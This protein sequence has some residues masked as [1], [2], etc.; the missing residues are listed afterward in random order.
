MQYAVKITQLFFFFLHIH[1]HDRV[2]QMA[3][4]TNT[5]K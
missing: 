2:Y 4:A 3:E 5:E 1:T